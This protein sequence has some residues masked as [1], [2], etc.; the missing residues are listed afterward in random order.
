MNSK[1]IHITESQEK[2][3]IE[4]LDKDYGKPVYDYLKS[5][6]DAVDFDGS[7][8]C[9][10]KLLPLFPYYF[11]NLLNEEEQMTVIRAIRKN[12]TL[13]DA[14][15]WYFFN[16]ERKLKLKKNVDHKIVWRALITNNSIVQIMD[17]FFMWTNSSNAHKAISD[18]VGINGF[19]SNMVLSQAQLE[20]PQWLLHICRTYD[21]AVNIAHNGFKKGLDKDCMPLLAYSNK[22]SANAK[23]GGHY[24]YAWAV[25]DI[26]EGGFSSYKLD[27][28]RYEKGFDAKI[29]NLAPAAAVM[30]IAP[31]IKFYH[32]TDKEYQTIFNNTEAHDFVL[33]RRTMGI[34]R[35]DERDTRNMHGG[36]M[37]LVM[38]KDEQVIY[39]NSSISKAIAWAT[40]NYRQYSKKI[41]QGHG[42]NN[43]LSEAIQNGF[44][45]G[46]LKTLP[47]FAAKIKYCTEGLGKPIGAGSSRIVFQIDDQWVL[48]LAKNTKGIVQN[49]Y[50]SNVYDNYKKAMD[51]T[52]NINDRLSDLDNFS[53]I[54]SEYILPL[55]S[56][57]VEVCLGMTWEKFCHFLDWSHSQYARL[58]PHKQKHF[59]QF[60]EEYCELLENND[61]CHE[62]NDYLTNY[63]LEKIGDLKRK[64]NWGYVL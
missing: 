20:K 55:K 44:S 31:S 64:T 48:K 63:G 12:P 14:F 3:L 58:A 18:T 25:K 8:K 37:W 6:Q 54:V 30:F 10:E 56:K 19:E 50:E 24:S 45:F 29:W 4:Y 34:P 9:T 2:M 40:Q 7:F 35:R 51:F 11:M 47:S 15:E 22:I 43:T 33:L 41:S 32:K 36:N 38:D 39:Q 28:A 21:D 59:R 57:D 60:D 1:K 52:P 62:I 42:K 61:F 49:E 53:Y 16:E 26:L 13:Y 27:G 5:N 17:N 23:D 46:Y